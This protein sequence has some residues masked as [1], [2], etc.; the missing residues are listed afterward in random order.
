MSHPGDAA[1]HMAARVREMSEAGIA[2]Q[3]LSPTITPYF[4]SEAVSVEAARIAN[5]A[6]IAAAERVPERFMVFAVLPMPHLEAARA[7]LERML[8]HPAVAGVTLSCFYGE[9]SAADPFFEPLY[10]DLNRIG[11]VVFFHPAVN[12]LCSKFITDWKLAA[13]AGAPFED[14]VIAMHLMVAQIPT[15]YPRINFIV[16]HLAGGLSTLLRRLDNQLP[17]FA[18]VS[19]PPSRTA[20]RFWY[21][22][23]CH[24]SATALRSAV[25]AFGPDRLLPGSDYPFL[26]L[27][28][29]YR[30]TFDF[31]RNIGLPASAVESVLRRNAADLFHNPRLA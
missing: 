16:P 8:R 10:A 31:I 27:H 7:E 5:D 6:L 29:S 13:A 30:D 4:D 11:A 18:Q 20:K 28:E 26:T 17:L 3:I 15:R 1:E 12:G 23:C 2:M 24:G 9:R 19:E 21:D 22:T 14:T 25:E